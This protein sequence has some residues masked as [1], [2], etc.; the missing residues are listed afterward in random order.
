[1]FNSVNSIAFITHIGIYYG[2]V[3]ETLF[4]WK[5]SVDYTYN[6]V[7]LTQAIGFPLHKDNKVGKLGANR[8]LFV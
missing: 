6:I 2:F 5:K 1:M 7:M 4:A 8:R 3:T